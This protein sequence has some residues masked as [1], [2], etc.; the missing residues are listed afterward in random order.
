M[1]C[2][3]VW[4]LC[5]PNLKVPLSFTNYFAAGCRETPQEVVSKMLLQKILHLPHFCSFFLTVEICHHFCLPSLVPASSLPS[6]FLLFLLFFNSKHSSRSESAE[7]A[8]KVAVA[9][10][11]CGIVGKSL[12]GHLS[13]SSLLCRG[14]V[15]RSVLLHALSSSHGH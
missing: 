4:C 8:S 9:S 3:W 5:C 1:G 7:G 14:C 10:T 13:W 11:L 15:S 6:L 2:S 12:Q